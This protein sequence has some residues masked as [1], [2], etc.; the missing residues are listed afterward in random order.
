MMGDQVFVPVE[1]YSK[2]AAEKI[3]DG[4]KLAMNLLNWMELNPEA[5][6]SIYPNRVE[7]PAMAAR[8]NKTVEEIEHEFMNQQRRILI[9]VS[10]LFKPILEE[11]ARYYNLEYK[12]DRAVERMLMDRDIAEAQ[13]AGESDLNSDDVLKEIELLLNPKKEN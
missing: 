12:D 10:Y 11:I 3:I 13:M 5:L 4:G 6:L 9:V 1:T 8:E 7:F 2:E